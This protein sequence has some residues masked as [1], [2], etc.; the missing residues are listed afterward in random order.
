MT[1]HSTTGETSSVFGGGIMIIQRIAGAV[2]LS[3]LLAACGPQTPAA[4]EPGGPTPELDFID[5]VPID[6]DAPA[7]IAR[8][9]PAAKKEEPETEAAAEDKAPDAEA[10]SA[11]PPS[12]E[13]AA[14]ADDAATATR[15]ANETTATPDA[16]ATT[17]TPDPPN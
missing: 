17:G 15:Q 10:L 5:A 16:G 14:T 7:P 6:E 3:G 2:I 9:Q 4:G 13:P 8:P 11:P 1:D 12:P